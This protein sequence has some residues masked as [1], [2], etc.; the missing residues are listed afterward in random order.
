MTTA[1]GAWPRVTAWLKG[2]SGKAADVLPVRVGGTDYRP[3]RSTPAAVLGFDQ[4][5]LWVVV[6]LLAWGLVMVYSA[7]IAMPDNPRFGKI[8]ATH[9]LVRHVLALVIGFVVALLAFQVSMATWERVAPW[10]FV[11]SIVLLVAVLIPH[12]GTVV[13]GARRWL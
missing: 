1:T 3:T 11:V 6:A 7:S 12:V 4:A 2:L 9:F 5:L 8:A 13:N 10:L